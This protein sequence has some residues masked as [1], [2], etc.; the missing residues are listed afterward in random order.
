MHMADNILKTQRIT[1]GIYG[2]HEDFTNGS[3]TECFI[4]HHYKAVVILPEVFE[5]SD[6]DIV[7]Q[8]IKEELEKLRTQ[9]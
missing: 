2:R 1:S 6:K 9:P 7:K 5:G 4:V 8:L 3:I